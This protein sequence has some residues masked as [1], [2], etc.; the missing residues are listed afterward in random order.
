MT[1]TF[2]EALGLIAARCR[3]VSGVE[4]VT[5]IDVDRRILADD[6]VA[7]MSVPPADN[8]AV[9]G[10]AFRHADMTEEGRIS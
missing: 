8:S 10:Y 5:L 7:P 2:A 9:D 6:I 4:S 3:P 1:V